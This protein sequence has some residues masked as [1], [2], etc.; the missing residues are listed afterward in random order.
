MIRI[1]LPT[2]CPAQDILRLVL[3]H[4]PRLASEPS[5][6]V[7]GENVVPQNLQEGEGASESDDFSSEG[8]CTQEFVMTSTI[9]VWRQLSKLERYQCRAISRRRRGMR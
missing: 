1:H 2:S 6:T 9:E 3:G 7:L 4:I 8:S 5:N